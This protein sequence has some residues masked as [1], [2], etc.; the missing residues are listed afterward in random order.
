[1]R[2]HNL[3]SNNGA[4]TN[5]FIVPHNAEDVHPDNARISAAFEYVRETSASMSPYHKCPLRADGR[6]LALA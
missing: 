4:S 3:L 2:H 5:E 6:R 1:M